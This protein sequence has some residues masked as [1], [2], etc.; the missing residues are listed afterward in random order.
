MKHE[1]DF[2]NKR[3]FFQ[4]KLPRQ[5]FYLVTA[6]IPMKR[7]NRHTKKALTKAAFKKAAFASASK[8]GKAAEQIS[9]GELLRQS[10]SFDFAPYRNSSARNSGKPRS[11]LLSFPM[12]GFHRRNTFLWR[13]QRLVSS[14]IRTGF[15]FHRPYPN[16]IAGTLYAVFYCRHY[17]TTLI[18]LRQDKN[19]SFVKKRL[20]K[21][22]S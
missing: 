9:A 15:P 1:N 22:F 20:T 4:T 16:G 11:C 6:V 7:I 8:T 2:I 13:T 14:R 18:A 5:V 10:R 17:L 3:G 19:V 21:L 12:T